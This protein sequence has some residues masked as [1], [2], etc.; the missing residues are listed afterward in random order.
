MLM[1]QKILLILSL[2]LLM[3]HALAVAAT[4][5][6][7]EGLNYIYNSE[8]R[9][10]MLTFER[11]ESYDNYKAY[12]VIN[13]PP[14]VTKDGME[15][16]VTS[17]GPWAL[18]RVGAKSITLPNTI[19][20][21]Y[22]ESMAR[23][24]NVEE[25]IVPNS[26][27]TIDDN[28]FMGSDFKRVVIP[29]SVTELAYGACAEMNEL[30]YIVLGE[31]L[32]TIG[33][34]AFNFTY[35]IE[36]IECRAVYPPEL[37]TGRSVT[38]T[39]SVLNNTVLL[40]PGESIGDYR[41]H[42][43]WGQ[44]KNI[45][46]IESKPVEEEQLPVYDDKVLVNG[47]WY[48]LYPETRTA[49]ATYHLYQDKDNYINLE[50]IIV[51]PTFIY[52]GMQYTVT[53]IGESAFDRCYHVKY[54]SI[55]ETVT[56]IGRDGFCSNRIVKEVVIG[57][58]VTSIGY[59]AFAYNYELEHLS[60]GANV[61]TIGGEA[62][63][64]DTKLQ[65]IT[66]YA[67]TPPELTSWGNFSSSTYS[68]AILYVPVG[69]VEIYS[70]TPGWAKFK[71]IREISRLRVMVDGI[72]YE[73]NL[74]DH[75]CAVTYEASSFS[76]NYQELRD[77]ALPEEIIYNGEKFNVVALG[78]HAFDSSVL[79]SIAL[80]NS[81]TEIGIAALS[82]LISTIDNV[83]I[84]DNVTIV[85]DN[86]F[87]YSN[88]KYLTMG[89]NL[90]AI[91]AEA[92]AGMK[93]LVSVSF[94]ESIKEI[95]AGAFMNSPNISEI[96]VA[97]TVPPAINNEATYTFDETVYANCIL[98][99]PEEAVEAYRNAPVWSLF[100]KIIQIR[101]NNRI[102]VDGLY[103][104][105]DSKEQTA[106]VTYEAEESED[107]YKGRIHITI[108]AEITVDGNVY[109]VTTIGEGA[110][111][112]TSEL[113][114]V[115][116]PSSILKIYS[117]AFGES[118]L[119]VITVTSETPAELENEG[120]GVFDDIAYDA[121]TVYVPEG[122]LSAY[123]RHPG[124]SK[125][126]DLQKIGVVKIR[127]IYYI[128]DQSNH[129]AK[130]TYQYYQSSK[131]YENMRSA[132]LPDT[133]YW[134]GEQYTVT[135]IGASSFD[136]CYDITEI[137][138]PNSVTEIETDGFCSNR[139]LK[140]V[141]IGD[142]VTLIGYGAFAFN[143]ELETV[144]IG[145]SV[146]TLG[147]EAF[148]YDSKLKSVV[149]HA[150]TPPGMLPGRSS[151]FSSTAYQNAILYVPAGCLDAYRNSDWRKFANIQ[152][153]KE[154]A[155]A[156]DVLKYIIDEETVEAKV[157]YELYND[158][159]NY[160]NI[161][162]IEI[163]DY[164]VRTVNGSETEYSVTTVGDHAFNHAPSASATLPGSIKSIGRFAFANMD[165][166]SSIDIPESVET[167]GAHAFSGD[168]QLKAVKVGDGVQTIG[169]GA[170]SDDTS[171]A[172]VD[173][174]MSVS[175]I[176]G[177]A[178]SQCENLL[179]ITVRAIEPPTLEE[180]NAPTFTASAYRNA[181]LHVPAESVEKYVAHPIW[182]L[183]YILPLDEE[184]KRIELSQTEGTVRIG[185]T[186]KLTAVVKPESAGSEKITWTSSD[187]ELAMVG[188][189]GAVTVVGVGNVTIT[190]S[191]LILSAECVLKCYPQTGDANWSGDI[192][193]A[194][195]V[196][197]TNYVVNKKA[198]PEDWNEE[199][200][201]EFYT[202]G[203]NANLS[204]EGEISFA[205]ALAAVRL[206]LAATP[207]NVKKV[208]SVGTHAFTNR[209]SMGYAVS[210]ILD[211]AMMVTL[212]N[213]GEYVAMQADIFEPEGMTIEVKKG[214]GAAN[215]SLETMKVG[216]NL[217][218]VALFNLGNKAFSIGDVLEIVADGNSMNIDD[219]VLANILVADAD[220][221]E[222]ALESMTESVTGVEGVAVGKRIEIFNLEGQI[223][224]SFEAEEK[225]DTRGLPA[226]IYIVKEGNKTYKVIL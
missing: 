24:P 109:K 34:E 193:I 65:D 203:A 14:V 223:V 121:A 166:L 56:K 2:W 219:L 52:E 38:F 26:V 54:I 174:G 42:R 123:L 150:P 201:L 73:L 200:W 22:K 168:A 78:N 49:T 103:Y 75:T 83:V 208:S 5:D 15:F 187:E 183:F 165:N 98:R 127:G 16:T 67:T 152:E 131:N 101:S 13:V 23:I 216:D 122:A 6:Y 60:I 51:P 64:Y 85:K 1:K 91:G 167:I 47:I 115:D 164:I 204:E 28:A 29:S 215:H 80:S 106:S 8:D 86:A 41:S 192:T 157:T 163:P 48:Y 3:P 111:A 58:N 162:K 221:N 158:S 212:D 87:A 175:V 96:T 143:Y 130:T 132:L 79:T 82:N 21:I 134:K 196:D 171:L 149:C 46:T 197:I 19:T 145:K 137:D 156:T 10:A 95:G 11:Q 92:C 30:K 198:E 68:T 104:I 113:K 139:S 225:L 4:G 186:L 148:N 182:S 205:D 84:P 33:G 142:N 74:K 138:I 181:R 40:V 202:A 12:D 107:N 195:A 50:N 119:E 151:T 207:A 44:F 76:K 7:T 57:D 100:S 32:T 27:I 88:I 217:I 25:L 176:E 160:K 169:Y 226:G 20:R 140:N 135:K 172:E 173:L 206:A 102:L 114:S 136:R 112:K 45:Q 133:I 55:P 211:N 222:Y 35:N 194:D 89:K 126:R 110:F 218:R 180:G 125:F 63:N 93:K 39:S 62:F 99:V 220:A 214:S 144:E 170:F 155:V 147:G 81:I 66:V 105:L 43:I 120:I 70:I 17:I 69:C 117:K 184:S 108:P 77:V 9:T 210:T 94:E 189:D 199:E 71:N 190:A 146:K 118:G 129:T 31:G 116:I 124:W 53:E 178:F 185:E 191:Y 159:L 161:Q 188:E 61:K 97:N 224:K 36:T 72:W 18:N 153:L 141:V 177:E 59:G 128:L 209:P 37:I 154:E 179:N 90:S 213:A